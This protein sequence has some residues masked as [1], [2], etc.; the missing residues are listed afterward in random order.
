MK[1]ADCKARSD[2]TAPRALLGISQLT[3]G[4]QVLAI[5]NSMSMLLWPEV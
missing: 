1:Q 2:P 4:V 3:R 5:Y